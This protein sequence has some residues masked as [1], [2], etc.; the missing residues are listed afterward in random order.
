MHQRPL[1]GKLRPIGVG[2]GTGR[3]WNH[4]RGWGDGGREGNNRGIADSKGGVLERYV[5]RSEWW[6]AGEAKHTAKIA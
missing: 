6:G 4:W 3:Y 2:T 5:V 1:K